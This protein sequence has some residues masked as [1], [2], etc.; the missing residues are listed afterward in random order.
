VLQRRCGGAPTAPR[1][2]G[3]R[4][5]S[6]LAMSRQASSPSSAWAVAETRCKHLNFVPFL[7]QSSY[8]VVPVDPQERPPLV[9]K[10]CR[11][12]CEASITGHGMAVQGQ[13]YC[14][15]QDPMLLH[16]KFA[17]AGA[18]IDKGH[19]VRQAAQHPRTCGH[20]VWCS[21]CWSA[22]VHAAPPQSAVRTQRLHEAAE[23]SEQR[24]R[25]LQITVTSCP[26]HARG[27]L[28]PPKHTLAA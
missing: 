10:E 18:K 21:S 5:A 13:Q 11:L 20:Y 24:A 9:V 2:P 27:L 26:L 8:K 3:R 6:S 25:C 22:A 15:V 1:L 14:G 4:L 28:A 16:P 19:A 17:A 7:R 23:R 12:D